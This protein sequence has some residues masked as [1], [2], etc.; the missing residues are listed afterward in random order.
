MTPAL[1]C[2]VLAQ[3]PGVGP[4]GSLSLNAQTP[5][6]PGGASA[7][8]FGSYLT[9]EETPEVFLSFGYNVNPLLTVT[10]VDGGAAVS[11]SPPFVVLAADGGVAILESRRSVRYAPGQGVSMRFT[12]LWDTCRNGSQQVVGMGTSQDGYFFGCC[13]ACAADGGASFGVLRRSN[14]TDNW[15]PQA[16]WNGNKRLDLVR[17]RGTPYQIQYQWLG[18]GQ[19]TFLI[20]NPTTGGFEVAHAIRYANTSTET[21]ILRPTLPL[22]AEAR[23]NATLKVPSMSLLRQGPRPTGQ[24]V[25]RNLGGTKAAA[26]ASRVPLFSI[27]NDSTYAGVPNR[28]Q[29]APDFISLANGGSVAQTVSVY[30]VLN[31]TLTNA[32]YSSVDTASSPASTSTAQTATSGGRDLFR[33]VVEGGGTTQVDL[34]PYV[35]EMVPGDV[36]SVETQSVS[37]TP[38]VTA[39][40]S[41]VEEF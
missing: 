29:L 38:N 15:T 12:A 6:T 23:G 37:G 40:V 27:R 35:L 24:S 32:S 36:L 21:S 17:T 33:V 25:R 26:S 5:I 13:P 20:E 16:L 31:P 28:V 2:L 30:L 41:W 9:T 4:S 3:A 34:R 39:S 8:A 10:G 22:R 18:Y 19:Q 7:G 1:L 11:S 14:G